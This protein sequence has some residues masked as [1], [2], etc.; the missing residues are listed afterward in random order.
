MI[1]YEDLPEDLQAYVEDHMMDG[2]RVHVV[3]AEDVVTFIIHIF[4]Q[5]DPCISIAQWMSGSDNYSIVKL[6]G[7]I[8]SRVKDQLNKNIVAR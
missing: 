8:L 3:H 4:Q 7:Q 5:M 2:N 6:E 1:A